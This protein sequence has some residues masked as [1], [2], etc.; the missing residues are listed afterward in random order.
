MTRVFNTVVKGEPFSV[1]D[2][3]DYSARS[4]QKETTQRRCV[5]TYINLISIGIGMRGKYEEEV[6]RI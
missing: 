1:D 6:W 3:I 4:A 5:E 2:G